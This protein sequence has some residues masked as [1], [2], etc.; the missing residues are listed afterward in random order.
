[1]QALAEKSMKNA[2]NTFL[3][4][5]LTFPDEQGEAIKVE[6]ENFRISACA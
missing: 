2:T 1:V 3:S 6:A 5:C 4:F